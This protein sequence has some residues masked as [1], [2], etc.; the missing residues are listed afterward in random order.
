MWDLIN[1]RVIRI[2]CEPDVIL[3][4]STNQ[5][6]A[7][8]NHWIILNQK[9]SAAL[10][11]LECRIKILKHRFRIFCSEIGTFANVEL[12]LPCSFLNEKLGGEKRSKAPKS[13]NIDIFEMKC[14]IWTKKNLPMC[15]IWNRCQFVT[16]ELYCTL[17]ISNKTCP[18]S[19]RYMETS[20]IWIHTLGLLL[21]C[22]TSFWRE[23]N[24]PAKYPSK[25]TTWKCRAL[26]YFLST[27]AICIVS[28]Y[29][30]EKNFPTVVCHGVTYI[31]GVRRYRIWRSKN[32]RFI[33]I[34]FYW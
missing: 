17:L 29:F 30:D 3:P 9:V 12:F 24:F 11:S 16:G 26:D 7:T 6:C 31:E 14:P 28:I 27:V 2:I 19:I 15:I 20:Q 5:T 34:V 23:K 32:F 21:H 10:C 33:E 1:G 8:L 4:L 18:K 22:I 25:F 13:K